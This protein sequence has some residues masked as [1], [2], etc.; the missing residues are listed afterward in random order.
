MT[1]S[2]YEI[3]PEKLFDFSAG[4]YCGVLMP[5]SVMKKLAKLQAS[6]LQD[7]Q[8]LLTEHKSELYPSSWTLYYPEG[9]QTS[10]YYAETGSAVGVGDIERR[11]KHATLAHKPTLRPLVFKANSMD[12]AKKMAESHHEETHI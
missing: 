8:R 10:V 6:Y 9:K 7:V 5:E 2:K 12:E 1:D 11:I 4:V 3:V